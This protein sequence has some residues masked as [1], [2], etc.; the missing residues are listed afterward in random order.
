MAPL[1]RDGDL[2]EQLLAGPGP[3]GSGPT[4]A[5]RAPSAG[6]RPRPREGAGA[7]LRVADRAGQVFHAGMI[8][9]EL[10]R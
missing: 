8:E 7:L 9:G 2:R 1:V 3:A 5:G 4:A 6:Q 10:G